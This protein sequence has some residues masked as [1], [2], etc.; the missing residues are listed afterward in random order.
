M[1]DEQIEFLVD[2]ADLF[3][4]LVP[5]E[6]MVLDGERFLPNDSLVLSK[7]YIGG[8]MQLVG[9][10][11]RTTKVSPKGAP[12]ASPRGAPVAPPTTDRVMVPLVKL[13]EREYPVKRWGEWIRL[14][15]KDG[16]YHEALLVAT[17]E[18]FRRLK[19]IDRE[20]EVSRFERAGP[21]RV[22]A[23]RGSIGH[24][25]VGGDHRR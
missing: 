9:G 23:Q 20:V 6:I 7:L 3:D 25:P 10:A 11:P 8:R 12:K 15:I 19:P 5:T 18:K 24:R 1:R 13:T 14:G 21:D 22:L 2:I 16:N 17:S 4:I